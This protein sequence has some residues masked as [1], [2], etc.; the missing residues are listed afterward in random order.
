M[1]KYIKKSQYQLLLNYIRAVVDVIDDTTVLTRA[2]FFE[3][4]FEVF[5]DVV[6]TAIAKRSNA[7]QASIG[8][9]L[10]PLKHVGFSETAAKARATKTTYLDLIKNALK[11]SVSISD[12]M[13]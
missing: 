5:D 2:A 9:V 1:D 13:V 8:E 12:S 11:K 4:I 3:S 7:K 6:Q 10:A